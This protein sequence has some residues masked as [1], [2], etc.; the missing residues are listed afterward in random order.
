MKR[1]PRLV[2]AALAGVAVIAG[3]GS[4]GAATIDVA[5][6]TPV[7]MATT[8]I[9]ADIVSNV[10][11]GGMVEI[12]TLIPPGSDPHGFEP[13]LR[14]RAMLGE[15]AMV[16]ANGLALEATFDDVLDSVDDVGVRVVRVGELITPR[17]FDGGHDHH[18]G[19]EALSEHDHDH[20]GDEAL[21]EHDHD[22]DDDHTAE[23]RQARDGAGTD[24]HFWLDPTLIARIL[25]DLGVELVEHAGVD[26]IE[27]DRCV[28]A[29]LQKL[30]EIDA[31][32]A[33][34]LG[35]LGSGQ[36]E[37]VTNH[38]VLGYFADRYDLRVLGT[39]HGPSTI[40][41]VAT[42][43]LGELAAAMAAHGVTTIFAEHG[44]STDVARALAGQT[45]A[46]V[47]LLHTESLSEPDGAGTY[48]DLLVSNASLIRDALARTSAADLGT[49]D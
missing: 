40:S 47:V 12:Q 23:I 1:P 18:D 25:P 48:L 15:A 28:D 38:G 2:I 31:R 30:E 5:D 13:S 24:P 9:W 11:C 4:N 46:F 7:V 19:D 16:V 44:S 34:M 3:C 43:Q 49:A 26:R 14:D 10:G 36:R 8:S 42:G 21:S 37:I 27:V 39:I 20:A 41:E 29:Y 35:D 17:P 22:H 45:G 6:Q 33:S 32:I